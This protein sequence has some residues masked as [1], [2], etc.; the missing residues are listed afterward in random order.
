MEIQSFLIILFIIAL[1]IL[2]LNI[3][4]GKSKEYFAPTKY[5]YKPLFFNCGDCF[6]IKKENQCV[7]A[8]T[9]KYCNIPCKWSK[10]IKHHP[11]GTKSLNKFCEENN[12]FYKIRIW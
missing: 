5:D 12:P 8:L 10:T 3:S 6:R 4:T 9:G 2:V 11:D 1:H 7:K